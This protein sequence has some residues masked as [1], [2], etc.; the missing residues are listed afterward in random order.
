MRLTVLLLASS[1]TIGSAG[2]LEVP[3]LPASAKKLDAAGIAEL[4]QNRRATFDNK[5]NKVTLTGDV[6]Y[7][8]AK[9]KTWGN[10]VWDKKK[11]G[12]FAGKIWAKGD[13]Y[14][15]KT[16]DGTQACADVYR[17]GDMW[18]ETDKKG[19]VLSANTILDWSPPP[20]PAAAKKV[21]AEEFMKAS[22]G[23]RVFVE[24]F[25]L[26]A[27]VVADLKWDWK[28]KR[29]TGDFVWDGVKKGKVNTK[30]SVEGDQV[31]GIN[32][33]EKQKNCY[34]YH[35]DDKGFWETTAEGKVHARS[36]FW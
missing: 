29:V 8:L 3:K 32:K 1:L 5:M 15:Y 11:R 6:W 4:F 22:N 34:S 25:D 17:D 30:I 35:M 10:Y 24:V 19:T 26:D 31:C 18:Y 14:C 21:T 13:Q 2:A 9:G 23:K 28:K 36:V 20:L 12:V 33:G 7:D 27:P 16:D